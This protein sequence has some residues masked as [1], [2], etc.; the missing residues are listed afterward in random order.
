M[1]LAE[2]LLNR[3]E[4][5][6]RAGT[7][8]G[9]TPLADVN[10]VRARV[11]LPPLAVLTLPAILRERKLE[12]AFEGFRLG[13]LKRNKESVT[14]PKGVVLAWNS[15]RLVFPIPLREINVNPNLTQNEGY[16]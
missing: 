14:D 10:R 15:P 8:V 3:A 16:Q 5:N 4:A 2:M 7:T 9:A 1:R 11:S 6:F 13:D 12:L